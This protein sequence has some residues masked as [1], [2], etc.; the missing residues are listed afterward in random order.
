MNQRFI[1]FD[2]AIIAENHFHLKFMESFFIFI[3]RFF[4]NF[5]TTLL[6]FFIF[7]E[8]KTDKNL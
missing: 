6:L 4:K 1:A 2:Y 3:C 8:G 5:L 7:E